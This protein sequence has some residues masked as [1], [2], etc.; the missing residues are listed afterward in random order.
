VCFTR[1]INTQLH[2]GC[3]ES[4][5]AAQPSKQAATYKAAEAQGGECSVGCTH[6][7][8]LLQPAP[9]QPSATSLVSCLTAFK[10]LLH[11]QVSA[12]TVTA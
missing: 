8:L 3:S 1:H 6:G 2:H 7:S 11:S 4:Y 12:R 9:P 5:A 10:A